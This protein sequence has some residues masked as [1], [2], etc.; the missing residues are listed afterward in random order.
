MG[1]ENDCP[2]IIGRGRRGKLNLITDVPGVKVGHVTVS[3]GYINT[4]VTAVLPH[5]G[6]LFKEKVP[7]GCAIINGF[8]KTIGLMQINELGTTV[9]VVSH[10]KELVNAL[11]KRVVSLTDGVLTD[12]GGEYYK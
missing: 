12:H 7:A 3:N 9:L 4:G 5:G 1:L 2:Y 10:E 8:G 11:G 6:N